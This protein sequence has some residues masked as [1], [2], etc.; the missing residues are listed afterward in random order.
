MK[1]PP[2]W[3]WFSANEKR[4]RAINTISERE[5]SEIQ[6]WLSVHLKYYCSKIGHRLTIPSN[7]DNPA[8]FDFSFSN[9][10][11]VRARILKLLE[12]APDLPNWHFSAKINALIEEYPDYYEEEYCIEGV[13][14]KPSNLKFW[15]ASIDEKTEK[16]ILGITPNFPIDTIDPDAL[17]QVV[18]TIL[19]DTIGEFLYKRFILKFNIHSHSPQEVKLLGGYELNLYLEGL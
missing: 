8:R 15:V 11:H 16:L 19:I 18:N 6:H 5:K 7:P 3:R 10:P 4:L 17:H 13:C 12:T 2:F 9:E 1:T 14:C